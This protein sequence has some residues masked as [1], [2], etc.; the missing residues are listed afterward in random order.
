MFTVEVQP[1]RH[2]D[3]KKEDDSVQKTE[4]FEFGSRNAEVEK[5]EGEKMRG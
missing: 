4:A 5:K 3:T 2:E 1:L